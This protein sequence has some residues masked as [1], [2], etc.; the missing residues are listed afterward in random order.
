MCDCDTI[1]ERSDGMTYSYAALGVLCGDCEWEI[2]REYV[3]Q[4]RRHRLTPV[5]LLVDEVTQEINAQR[6]SDNEWCDFY[7]SLEQPPF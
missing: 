2:E 4:E 7:P 5:A 6:F 1:R 3:E